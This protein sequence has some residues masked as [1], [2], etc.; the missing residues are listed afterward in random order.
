MAF[1]QYLATKFLSWYKNSSFPTALTNVYV[2]LH[3]ADPGTAGT[4]NDSTASIIGNA[5]RVGIA[6]TGFSSVGAAGGGGFQVTNSG[7]C[8]ITTSAQNSS[9]VT[10]THF[11]LWD[12]ATSGNFLA[13]GSLTTNV[14]VQL[15]DTVQFNSG[16]MAIKV[17]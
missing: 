1:S 4:N 13:S 10:V 15:G 14:D 2:S 3:T 7:V 5:T 8:Q 16:A 17:I 12:A 9:G 11:G 6:A